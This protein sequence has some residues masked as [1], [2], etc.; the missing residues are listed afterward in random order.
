MFFFVVFKRL[1]GSKMLPNTVRVAMDTSW[2]GLTS[3]SIREPFFLR[4]PKGN[5]GKTPGKS[6]EIRANPEQIQENSSLGSGWSG[7]I[8]GAMSTVNLKKRMAQKLRRIIPLHFGLVAFRSHFGKTLKPFIFMI[9]GFLDV[10]TTSKTN[11][12]CL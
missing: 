2:A 11:I 9:S 6:R 10:S 7:G 12:I 1:W 3:S 4:F 5:S 8:W